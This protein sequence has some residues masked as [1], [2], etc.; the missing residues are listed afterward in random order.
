[1][2]GPVGAGDWEI[3][4]VEVGHQF[5]ALSS[6]SLCIDADGRPH[7]AY[8]GSAL[9]YARY[10]GQS[11][12]LET[13]DSTFLVGTYASLAI[14]ELAIPH[15]AYYDE[16]NGDL[17][18]ARKDSTGWQALTVDAGGDVGRYASIRLD[19]TG[20]AHISYYDATHGDLKHAAGHKQHWRIETV[21]DSGDIGYWTSLAVDGDGNPH[22]VYSSYEQLKHAWRD[23]EGWHIEPVDSP[24]G[25]CTSLVFDTSGTPHVAYSAG[26]GTLMHAWKDGTAWHVEVLKQPDGNFILGYAYSSLAC[27]ES[28]T[29]HLSYHR[30]GDYPHL[31]GLDYARLDA[32]GW[33]FE[34]VIG[35]WPCEWT[36]L[37]SDDDG[38]VH[39]CYGAE[40]YPL[41]YAHRQAGAQIWTLQIV[42]Y[43]GTAG[44]YGDLVVDETG[45][46][47]CSYRGIRGELRYA[48]R[49]GLGWH[50]ETV[51][52]AQGSWTSL[53]LGSEGRPH[54]CY[55]DE[56]DSV[57]RYALWDVSD[58]VVEDVGT[59]G[60]YGSMILDSND[61]P[62]ISYLH[63]SPSLRYAHKDDL[64]WHHEAVDSGE[65]PIWYTSTTSI[66]LT[67]DDRPRISYHD[68]ELDNLKCAGRDTVGWC[69][70]IVDAQGLAGRYSSLALDAEGFA[71]MS[72][73]GGYPDFRL[74]YARENA[75]GWTIDIVD[76]DDCVGY[77][78]SLVLDDEG[79]PHIAYEDWDDDDLK[80]AYKDAASW[81]VERVD[82][83]G[84]VGHYASLALDQ[85]GQAHIT[86]HDWDL[87][88]LKYAYRASPIGAE[89]SGS[90][91]FPSSIR[92][93]TLAPN[94]TASEVRILYSVCG[95][96]VDNGASVSLRVYD[97]A[98]RLVAQPTLG[99]VTTGTG[100]SG[101]S[102]CTGVGRPVGPGVYLLRLEADSGAAS[103]AA[104]LVVVR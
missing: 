38:S 44:R 21:D 79:Y 70:E 98:G 83:L 30:E 89:G 96:G 5:S 41:K 16:D 9:F 43:P 62:H 15:V 68:S 56:A 27:D 49:S 72:Y 60:A 81:H 86:Y 8:G 65:G 104:R 42:D 4:T 50:A 58:W 87:G 64:G 103:E 46:P 40:R 78:T 90:R 31:S 91:A 39:L 13:A 17:K 12:Q 54:I 67:H 37:S 69:I 80:Y 19:C 76:E 11:W 95:A 77:Y 74:K 85:W 10:D 53:T 34:T 48:R 1:M 71:H 99:R 18:Y 100:A 29:L 36:S 23:N 33:H 25:Y 26:Y 75:A 55:N 93:L 61:Y 59:H 2:T 82:S 32:T 28:G 51:D 84:R 22:V 47:H 45:S 3:E 6:R 63:P 20:R 52:S 35:N 14:D 97:A 7:I 66:A 92:L 94:P 73:F 101:W 57:I 102:L 88:I 24:G